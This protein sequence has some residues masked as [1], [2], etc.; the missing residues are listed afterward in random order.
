MIF[1]EANHTYTHNGVV[2]QSVTNWIK[3]FVPE[4]PRD[5]IAGKTAKRDGVEVEEILEQWDM[6]GQASIDYGNSVHKASELLI[7]YGLYSKTPHLKL[8]AEELW[9][10]LNHTGFH[11][12]VIVYDDKLAGTI[13]IIEK[14]IKKGEVAI[15]DI[16]TGTDFDKKNGMLLGEYSDLPNNDMSK[17]KIQLT[18]YKELLE[19]MKDVKVVEM[20]VLHW[21]GEKFNKIIIK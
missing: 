6:K 4:F 13:D 10:M 20:S 19:G 12:E 15:H 14:T 1:D 2:L 21:D 3:Q 11:S 17:F 9:K 5:F 16:K 8:V 18:K 7:K